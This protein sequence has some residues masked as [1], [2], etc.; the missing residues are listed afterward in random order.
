MNYLYLIFYELKTLKL[1]NLELIFLTFE[2][3]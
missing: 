1:T 2:N 3:V